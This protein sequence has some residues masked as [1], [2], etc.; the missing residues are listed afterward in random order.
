MT[1]PL[2]VHI[3]ETILTQMQIAAYQVIRR[4]YSRRNEVHHIRARR[5]DGSCFDF[6]FKRYVT[7][8]VGTEYNCLCL[9][10]GI[11]IPSVL[12]KGES[13]LALEYIKGPLL[14]EKLEETEK[15]GE[16]FCFYVDMLIDYLERFYRALP[17]YIYGD[18]N[19]RN[20]IIAQDGLYGVDLEMVSKGQ[21][22]VDI[23]KAAAY[24]LTYSP[25]YTPYKKAIA[26]YFMNR[27][28][29]RFALSLSDVTDNM[30][31]ELDSMRIRRQLRN[32]RK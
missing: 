28:A 23:G 5:D 10:K 1:E 13:A 17:G 29:G 7:G 8:D 16:P 11:H 2:T 20:F 19:L 22:A 6:V 4:F 3:E 30:N 31:T 21:I 26:D 24:L 14:L 25:A 32:E 27:S 9:L 18:I 12:A 15:A